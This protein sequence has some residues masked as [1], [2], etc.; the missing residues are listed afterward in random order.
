M[1]LKN[2]IGIS[3]KGIEI[4]DSDGLRSIL[5]DLVYQAVFSEGDKKNELLTLIK[6]IAKAAGAVP[7]SIQTLY[8]RWADRIPVLLCRR[9]IYGDSHTI[10]QR[11]YSGRPLR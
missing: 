5:D 11:R 7:T 9:L 2:V 8:G 1:E 4:K 3:E 6:E 10:R